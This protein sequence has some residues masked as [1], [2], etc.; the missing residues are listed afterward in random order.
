MDEQLR[1]EHE[2]EYNAYEET[3]IYKDAYK[4]LSEARKSL[5]EH[6]ANPRPNSFE[7]E[8]REQYDERYHQLQDEM[9]EKNRGFI[10]MAKELQQNGTEQDFEQLEKSMSAIQ[11]EEV[12]DISERRGVAIEQDLDNFRNADSL[13]AVQAL[14]REVSQDWHPGQDREQQAFQ[15]ADEHDLEELLQ[16]TSLSERLQARRQSTLGQNF[17][18]QADDSEQQQMDPSSLPHR[19][20]GLAFANAEQARIDEREEMEANEALRQQFISENGR[21]PTE[22]DMDKM[23][24]QQAQQQAEQGQDE[25]LSVAPSREE[26]ENRSEAKDAFLSKLEARREAQQ[27]SQNQSREQEVDRER[28]QQRR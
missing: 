2:Q 7:T 21:A 27:N 12:A 3:S 28:E 6:R 26:V 14:N 11:Q 9:L 15:D 17:D 16:S 5:N 23:Y 13:E 4:S 19:G 10:E 24:E 20:L 22:A 8:E 25:A 1:E 18:E